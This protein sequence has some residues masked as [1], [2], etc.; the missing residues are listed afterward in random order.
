[1]NRP[2][3]SISRLDELCGERTRKETHHTHRAHGH[4]LQAI[5][6]G[7]DAEKS[8][9]AQRENKERSHEERNV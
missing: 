8:D 6:H 1:M 2:L 4:S 5:N 3:I 7:T 9:V